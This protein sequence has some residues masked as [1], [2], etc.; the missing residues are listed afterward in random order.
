M[1]AV[2]LKALELVASPE[3]DERRVR[4]E[5][6][7]E[8]VAA[9]IQRLGGSGAGG[10]IQPYVLGTEAAALRASAVLAERGLRVLPIRPPT[11]PRGT[12]RLRISLSAAHSDQD[13][14]RLVAGLEALAQLSLSPE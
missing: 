11:V 10:P 2:A 3:G 1:A 7:V 8:R 13:I 4:L 12:A 14:D 9:C 6:H 5:A